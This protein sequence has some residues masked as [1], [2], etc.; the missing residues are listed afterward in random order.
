MFEIL[1]KAE[2]IACGSKRYFTG[3]PCKRGNVAQRKTADSKCLCD[4]CRTRRAELDKPKYASRFR[5]WAD[6]NPDKYFGRKR[7]AEQNAERRKRRREQAGN[8]YDRAYYIANRERILERVRKTR[9]YD[10]EASRKYYLSRRDA[11]LAAAKAW[12]AANPER[13]AE[14]KARRRAAQAQRVPSWYGELDGF[15]FSE[16]NALA[17]ERSLATGC[18]HH[19]DH[20]VPMRAKKASGLHCCAN[21]QVIPAY[22]NMFKNNKLIMS[23][24]DQWLE[25]LK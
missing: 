3:K 21:L 23:E 19:V 6:R 18:P 15:A 25:Y 9:E 2:A 7:T 5:A 11:A 17:A 12:I 16:A 8:E 20:M 22:L 24:P 1:S 13:V 10:P 4:A 14:R